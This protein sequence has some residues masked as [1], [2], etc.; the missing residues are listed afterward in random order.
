MDLLNLLTKLPAFLSIKA[1]R[2]DILSMTSLNRL[3]FTVSFAGPRNPLNTREENMYPRCFH[4]PSGIEH[5]FSECR[6]S[7]DYW[8]SLFL[9]N[10]KHTN[11]EQVV[12]LV[13]NLFQYFLVLLPQKVSHLSQS[14]CIA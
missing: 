5:N 9:N 6:Q 13:M 3:V 11:S 8:S 10:K 12:R 4:K 2:F 14:L 7:F 1:L